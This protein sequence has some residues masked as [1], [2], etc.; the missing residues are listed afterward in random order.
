MT[1]LSAYKITWIEFAPEYGKATKKDIALIEGS[2]YI[3]GA[4]PNGNYYRHFGSRERAEE[5]LKT[6]NKKLSKHYYC[7]IF[8]D[9]QFGMRRRE[10]GYKVPF[11]QKQKE[12]VIK[13]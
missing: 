2:K 1:T 7:R 6:F 8:T 9:K 5:F 4:D 3:G 10:D 12:N 13:L 11:T